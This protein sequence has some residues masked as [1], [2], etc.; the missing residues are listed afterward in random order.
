MHIRITTLFYV[1][2]NKIKSEIMSFPLLYS[3]T[4]IHTVF[5][6]SDA[7]TTTSLFISSPEFV[8]CLFESG[9]YKYQQLPE[10]QSVEK[11]LIDTTALGEFDSFESRVMF[12]C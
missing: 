3:H 11:Q 4:H 8:Q 1:S 6:Q 10:R 7:A 9:V 2:Y 12:T 5:A